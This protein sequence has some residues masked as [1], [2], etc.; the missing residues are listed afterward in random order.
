VHTQNLQIRISK[1]PYQVRDPQLQTVTNSARRKANDATTV[2]R[3]LRQ[4]K[5]KKPGGR[6]LYVRIF[7]SFKLNRIYTKRSN[8]HKLRFPVPVKS[9]FQL[10]RAS[11]LVQNVSSRLLKTINSIRVHNNIP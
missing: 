4:R 8:E 3:R 1:K 10:F 5:L 6:D 11:C 2:I 9:T 7:T